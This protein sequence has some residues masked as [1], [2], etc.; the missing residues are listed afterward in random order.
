MKSLNLKGSSSS[1]WDI[2]KRISSKELWPI[3][4]SLY[5]LSRFQIWEN[6]IVSWIVCFV[7]SSTYDWADYFL[8]PSKGSFDNV[9]FTLLFISNKRSESSVY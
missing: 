6:P 1:K 7:F 8:W 9:I 2:I 3:H 4:G 5:F